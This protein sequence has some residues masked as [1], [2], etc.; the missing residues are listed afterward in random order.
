MTLILF[1]CFSLVQD[2]DPL[3]AAEALRSN[4]EY[5]AAEGRYLALEPTDDQIMVFGNGLAEIALRLGN[6]DAKNNF[7]GTL[8][9]KSKNWRKVALFVRSV[10]SAA[11][12]DWPNF[13]RSAHAFFQEHGP[14]NDPVRFR[15]LYY[16]ARYTVIKAEDLNI[17]SVETQWFRASRALPP[18]KTYPVL[19][20]AELPFP[21]RHGH[22]LETDRLFD[23][24]VPDSDAD[25][26][27]YFGYLLEIRAALNRA[28][29]NGAAKAINALAPLDKKLASSSPRNDYY[30]LL[31]AYYEQRGQSENAQI[32]ARNLERVRSWAILPLVG[33]P[34]RAREV[35]GQFLEPTVEQS[36]EAPLA[37]QP[38]AVVDKHAESGD[39][40]DVPVVV[41]DKNEPKRKLTFEN[42]EKQLYADYRGLE[43]KIISLDPDTTFKK[44][45]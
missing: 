44:D 17:D 19:D 28:D 33:F 2:E 27:R 29:L 32:V 26:D 20:L 13:E 18:E 31:K 37:E 11:Q 21:F 35:A 41:E 30:P 43:L 1:L 42:M 6:L 8:L 40:P 16:L 5:F 23:A 36:I 24:P 10:I 39:M 15:L 45:L 3:H 9:T 14:V 7:Y 12:N 4:G 38:D 25:E 22:L 34:G